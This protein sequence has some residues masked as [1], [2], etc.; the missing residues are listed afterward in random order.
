[1]YRPIIE[2][3]EGQD[4]KRIV[5]FLSPFTREFGWIAVIG[6]TTLK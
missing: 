5:Q 3:I 6:R 1:M 2:T 4:S